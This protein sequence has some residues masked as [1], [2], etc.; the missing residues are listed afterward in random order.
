MST[1]SIHPGVDVIAIASAVTVVLTT[2]GPD[3]VHCG[4]ISTATGV[5]RSQLEELYSQPG[6]LLLL[7]WD[8]VLRLKFEVLVRTAAELMDGR[9]DAIRPSVAPDATTRAVAHLLVVTH[10]FDELREV[11]PFDV[12]RLLYEHEIEEMSTVDRS[13]FRA[14]LGW[15]LGIALE[16]GRQFHDSIELLGHIGWTSGCWKRHVVEEQVDPTPPLALAFDDIGGMSQEILGACTRIIAEGGIERA[17]LLRIARMAGCPSE[18]VSGMYGRQE[19]LIA[20][21]IGLVFSLLFSYRRYEQYMESPALATMRLE[22]WLE[23]EVRTRRRALLESVMASNFLP[24][25]E[26]AF[27]RSADEALMEL[28]LSLLDRSEAFTTKA[29][30][31]FVASRQ[32][33]LGLGVLEEVELEKWPRDWGPFLKMFLFEVG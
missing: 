30:L 6:E 3:A 10:R 4:A 15:L 14:T 17:T 29:S 16:P 9:L 21:Y 25:L 1:E 11:V 22:V 8:T 12:Q 31:R 23:P 28:H 27:V 19:Y 26:S 33:V 13:V 18:V 2:H 5:P 20:D 24:F 32:V 7:A